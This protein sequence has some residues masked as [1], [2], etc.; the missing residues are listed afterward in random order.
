MDYLSVLLIVFKC[1]S[2]DWCTIIKFG[3]F[4]IN[5][6]VHYFISVSRFSSLWLCILYC[7]G[8]ISTALSVPS[9]SLFWTPFDLFHGGIR[10]M[11]WTRGRRLLYRVLWLSCSICQ[12]TFFMLFRRILAMGGQNPV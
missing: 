4:C 1:V 3:L 9:H 7:K 8:S 2:S 5:M 12:N 6:G 11:C 10:F